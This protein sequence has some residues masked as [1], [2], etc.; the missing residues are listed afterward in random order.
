MSP[1]FAGCEKSHPVYIFQVMVNYNEKETSTII[2]YIS[3]FSSIELCFPFS[4]MPN[5]DQEAIVNQL[6]SSGSDAELCMLM[7][8][9]V[10]S[11]VF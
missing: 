7:L 1:L 9:L 11:S 8:L 10:L 3:F 5:P 2:L 6:I 4:N